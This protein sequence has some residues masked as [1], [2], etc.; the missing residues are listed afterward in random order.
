MGKRAV[1]AA[2]WP[3][4]LVL[5]TVRPIRR[6]TALF[7]PAPGAGRARTLVVRDHLAAQ[8]AWVTDSPAAERDG[9]VPEP[10]SG[11][12]LD[13]LRSAGVLLPP[14]APP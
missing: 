7:R 3:W 8:L 12:L 11:G 10:P 9:V 4:R 2:T 14:E 13:R 5:D 1:L 6:P